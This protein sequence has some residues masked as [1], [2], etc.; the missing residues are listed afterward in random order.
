[1][2]IDKMISAFLICW[3]NIFNIQYIQWNQFLLKRIQSVYIYI[4]CVKHETEGLNE[5]EFSE[6]AISTG[7]VFEHLSAIRL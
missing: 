7:S 3:K 4:I 1:M 5:V 2:I 6:H